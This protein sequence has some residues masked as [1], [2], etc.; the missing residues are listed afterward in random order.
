MLYSR[1]L[2]FNIL[3][4]LIY[5]ERST[6]PRPFANCFTWGIRIYSSSSLNSELLRSDQLLTTRPSPSA[7]LPP[8]AVQG[9]GFR[10]SSLTVLAASLI[11]RVVSLS[12]CCPENSAKTRQSRPDYKTVKAR[13]WHWLEPCASKCLES[14][15]SSSLLARQRESGETPRRSAI[16]V[17]RPSSS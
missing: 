12:H 17:G 3:L 1:P 9:S 5:Q 6:A 7:L 14:L 15:L 16:R 11:P 13:F 10:S 4:K 8:A 2:Q